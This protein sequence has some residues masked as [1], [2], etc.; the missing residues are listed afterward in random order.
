MTERDRLSL[1]AE[2]ERLA[3][4]ERAER[5][6]IEAP[7]RVAEQKLKA[8]HLELIK[9]YRSR[10]LGEVCDS[11]AFCDPAVA[12][13][14]MTAKQADEFNRDEFRRYLNTHP[15]TFVND[16]LL[17][18]LGAY[19]DV[20]G[21][22]IV[23]AQMIENLI[24]RYREAGLLPER[25]APESELEPVAEPESPESPKP[26]LIDGWDLESGEPRKWTPRE[27]DRLSSTDYRR[28]LRLYKSDL[29]LPNAGPGPGR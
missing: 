29:A 26:G 6:R 2:R 18:R 20:N 8:T 24:E 25:P 13:V 3:A 22:R 17:E 1:R 27:L 19:F 10:L 5:E 23:S 14:R 9:V 12:D 11:D 28:A 4:E 21:L 7:I 16:E 15:D